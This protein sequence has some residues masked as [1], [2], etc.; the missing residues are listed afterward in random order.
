MKRISLFFII[1]ITFTACNTIKNN[2]HVNE[3]KKDYSYD[4]IIVPG[5]P[6][7]HDSVS[8]ILQAR[9][10]WSVFLYKK[11]L[12]KNIIY[13]GSDVYSPYY[14]SKIMAMIAKQNGIPQNVIYCDTIAQHGTENIYY[15]YV[16]AKKLGLTK[17]ALATD[18][19]QAAMMFFFRSKLARKFKIKGGLPLLNANFDE[20]VDMKL[21]IRNIPDS[22][23]YNPQHIDIYESQ[24][25]GE[26]FFGSMGANISWKD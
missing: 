22:L 2:N 14:E 1:T 20:I 4:A 17:I 13:S 26:R 3:F 15:S 24:T 10:K 11:G 23:A 25:P 12:T 19:F 18:P 9:I 5:V 7:F 8:T 16:L 6:Y 21:D